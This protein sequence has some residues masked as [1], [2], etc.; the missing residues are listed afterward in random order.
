MSSLE[1]LIQTLDPNQ[2]KFTGDLSVF[3]QMPQIMQS[4]QLIRSLENPF[5][6]IVAQWK[7][8]YKLSDI[9]LIKLEIIPTSKKYSLYTSILTLI[10]DVFHTCPSF[11]QRM[12]LV[13]QFILWLI[14]RMELDTNVKLFL[15]NLKLR[16]NLLID[17]IKNINYQSHSVVYY[18]SLVFDINIVVITK[19]EAEIYTS[20]NE[21]D[22]CK[23]NILLY[24]DDNQI[25]YP[26]TYGKLNDSQ[27]LVYHNN[28][29][30]KSIIDSYN[31]KIICKKS[32]CKEVGQQQSL[33][34]YG[35]TLES[36]R[37]EAKNR[38]LEI[39]KIS[40]ISGKSIY[41]TKAELTA[42]LTSST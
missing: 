24:K 39:K 1:Q 42:D 30:I 31:K 25:Y 4:S 11:G 19:Q 12:E 27:F 20:L 32:Y 5:L 16:P 36:L 6:N 3:G 34:Y 18:L 41:K 17:E 38:G 2:K 35:S 21:Y 15:K 28:N 7:N 23:V 40:E 8:L 9:D 13:N 29:V 33:E 10:Y 37:T 26:V 22:N 14:S